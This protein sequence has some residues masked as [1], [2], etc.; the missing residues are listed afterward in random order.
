MY[1]TRPIGNFFQDCTA[2]DKI[3]LVLILTVNVLLIETLHNR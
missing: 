2:F 1:I 3:I